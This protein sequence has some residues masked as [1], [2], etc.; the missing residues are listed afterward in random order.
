MGSWVRDL[1]LD[2]EPLPGALRE[3]AFKIVRRLRNI[4]CARLVADEARR[5]KERND[6]FWYL[7]EEISAYR[8]LL[9]TR[10]DAAHREAVE[11]AAQRLV[12][13]HDLAALPELIRVFA[14]LARRP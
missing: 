7:G 14:A 2:P 6:E 12:Q 9:D 10:P 5:L 1:G 11:A 8:A 4:D 13:S 3:Q